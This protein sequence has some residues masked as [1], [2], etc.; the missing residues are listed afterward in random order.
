[1][2][3]A[4][5]GYR[6]TYVLERVPRGRYVVEEARATIDDPF[7]LARVGGRPRRARRATRLPAARRARPA[8][9]RERRPRPGRPAAAAAPPVRLR[10]PLRARVRAGGVAAEGALA[11]DRA[12]RPADGEGARGRAARRDRGHARRGR[13]RRRRATAST[14]RCAPP[15]R[16]CVPTPSHGRRAVLA[17]NSA[18]AAERARHLAR[19]RLAGRARLLAEAE[20]DGTRPVVELLSREGGPGLAGA[21]DGRGDRSPL[22]RARDEARPARSRR[23]GRQRRLDR[24]AELRG[25][26]DEG[27]AGAAAAAGRRRRGRRPAA[28][29]L[30][31]RRSRRGARGQ[32]RAWVGR[33]PSLPSRPC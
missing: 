7:G 5:G 14:S 29:R 2:S 9:L 32:E 25:A 23:P 31:G 4:G 16:F 18:I 26:A 6:G 22:R 19:R 20:P 10:P 15:A 21:R 8:L 11:D 33:S 12:A 3:R 13:E 1:M 17:V 30:S 28:R 27:R 24:R